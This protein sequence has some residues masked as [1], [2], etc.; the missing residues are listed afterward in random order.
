MEFSIVMQADQAEDEVNR[1][2]QQ[3]KIM[4]KRRE[5]LQIAVDSVV[6]AMTFGLVSISE[7]GTITQKLATPILPIETLV[8]VP[9]VAP[10]TIMKKISELRVD[11]QT[12]RNMC[13]LKAYTNQSEGVIN[14]LE[15][16]DRN[17]ADSIAFFFQ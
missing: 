4:P 1:L 3:K 10:E 15:P 17:I 5:A 7:D 13:Y 11:N 8:Y 2:L 9:R 14:K 6:E 16:A 12:N